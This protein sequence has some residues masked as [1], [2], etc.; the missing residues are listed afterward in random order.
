MEVVI[1]SLLVALLVFLLYDRK[2]RFTPNIEKSSHVKQCDFNDKNL[3]NRCKEIRNGCKRLKDDEK[4]ITNNLNA[5]CELKKEGYTIRDTL[6]NRRDCVTDIE[7]LIRTTYAK[8]ELCSQI[9]NMPNKDKD[10]KLMD[11]SLSEK[12][13][14]FDK[15]GG[16][17]NNVF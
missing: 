10:E 9:K 5:G 2:E 7:R 11:L 14:G 3:N 4:A 15:N 17:S 13:K 6:N 12:M 8:K 1:I 16:F